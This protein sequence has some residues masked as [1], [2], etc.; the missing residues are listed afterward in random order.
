M[1]QDPGAVRAAIEQDRQELADTVQALAHKTD[2]KERV[3]ETVSKNADELQ[4][5]AS[6]TASKVGAVTPDQVRS[7]ARTAADSARQRPLPVAVAAALVVGLLL[8]RRWG[9]KR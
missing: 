1:A 4:R 7:G 2:V 9:R 8:G 3:R 6:D 5:K